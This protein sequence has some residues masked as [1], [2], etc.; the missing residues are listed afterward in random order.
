[1]YVEKDRHG[2]IIIQNIS[3]GEAEVL[4]DCFCSYLAGGNTGEKRTDAEKMI[5]KLKRELEKLY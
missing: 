4:D 1:M 3:P 5:V 2:Q